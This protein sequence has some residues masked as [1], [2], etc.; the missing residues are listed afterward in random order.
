[1]INFYK[2]YRVL[3][4]LYYGFQGQL[5][6]LYAG[7]QAK[8]IEYIADIFNLLGNKYAVSASDVGSALERSASSLSLAGN[9]IQESAAMATGITEVTQDS[10]RAGKHMPEH[11][12]IYGTTYVV[13][14]Y[15][16]S[17]KS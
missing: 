4:L 6:N 16:K 2:I 5:D 12:V 17:V 9:T 10:E 11:I 7:N 14:N 8:S 3:Q 13:W 1:M 15:G